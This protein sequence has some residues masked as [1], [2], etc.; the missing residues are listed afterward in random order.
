[1]SSS[2][3]AAPSALGTVPPSNMSN[4]DAEALTADCKKLLASLVEGLEEED[5]QRLPDFGRKEFDEILDCHL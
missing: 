5:I 1:M 2:R 3:H 4:D